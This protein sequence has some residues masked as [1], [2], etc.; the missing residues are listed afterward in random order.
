MINARITVQTITG[1]THVSEPIEFTE[2][3][4]EKM[5]E[6]ARHVG[7]MDYFAI[8]AAD[9]KTYFH[10]HHIVSVTLE[11]LEEPGG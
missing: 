3:D 11:V 2:D 9:G 6:L 1:S 8:D 7:E 5:E 4:W 10:P